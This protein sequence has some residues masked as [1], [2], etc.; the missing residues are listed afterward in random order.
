DI[1]YQQRGILGRKLPQQRVG[2]FPV[3]ERVG[4]LSYRIELP[5]H[6][7]IHNVILVAHL[8]PAH[9]DTYQR[10][11]PSPSPITPPDEQGIAEFE[12]DILLDRRL[13]RVGRSR[14]PF[15]EYLVR[16]KGYGPEHDTWYREEEL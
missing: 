6:W 9:P 7:R 16:W 4:Q 15:I 13:R 14:T 1:P 11:A 10:V 12:I 8:E 2:P 3:L 5:S